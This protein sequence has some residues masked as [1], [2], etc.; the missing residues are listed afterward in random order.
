MSLEIKVKT[1]SVSCDFHPFTQPLLDYPSSQRSLAWRSKALRGRGLTVTW[2]P[3]LSL[4]STSPSLPLPLP[5][6]SSSSAQPLPLP[7]AATQIQLWG[8]GERCKLPPGQREEPPLKSNLV[9]F[10]HF[11]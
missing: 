1:R 10:T 3:S 8:L 7:R 11:M 9:H 4:P 6:L 5:F 2:G